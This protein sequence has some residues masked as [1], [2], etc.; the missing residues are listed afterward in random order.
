MIQGQKKKE[1]RAPS[2]QEIEELQPK[3]EVGCAAG[4]DVS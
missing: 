3:A 2:K 1:V 4:P